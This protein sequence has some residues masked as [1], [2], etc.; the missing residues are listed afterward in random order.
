LY[1]FRSFPARKNPA[2]AAGRSLKLWIFGFL[3]T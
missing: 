2:W 3:R 1:F